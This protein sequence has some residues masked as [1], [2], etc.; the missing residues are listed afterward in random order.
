M[1]KKLRNRLLLT[2][3][4]ITAALIT[5]C[6]TVIFI[7]MEQNVSRNTSMALTGA[8]D[9]LTDMARSEKLNDTDAPPPA[10][11]STRSPHET[12]P[13]NDNDPD[14]GRPK[15]G[16]TQFS[17]ILMYT[18]DSYGNITDRSFGL[19]LTNE[20][21]LEQIK[22]LIPEI[23]SKDVESGNISVNGTNLEYKIRRYS[24][25]SALALG[26]FSAEHAILQ[27]LMIVLVLIE[28]FAL[29]LTL[30]IS[31]I[32][33]NRSIRPVEDSYNKQKQFVADASHELKT[34]LTTINTNIDV[35]LSHEDSLI[36]DEKKWLMYIRSENER[37][38]KLTNDLL[39]L[40]RLDH[41]ENTVYSDTSF[42]DAAE[43][44]ILAME[45]VAFERN[46]TVN[47]NIDDGVIVKA[48]PEQLR[49]LIMIL[50][51]NAIKYTPDGGMISVSLSRGRDAVL[52]I[53][54]SGAGIDKDDIKQIF[55]R[56]YRSDRSRARE[57]GGYG[58]GLAIA[59]AITEN[60][61]GV[62]SVSSKVNEYTEFYVSIP[63]E[64]HK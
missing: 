3:L 39:Y 37:M 4:L 10:Q 47:E 26:E 23:I 57:S 60:F 34:P 63:A 45:A 55:E 2:N 6:F 1:F 28:I 22:N 36:R 20:T 24:G 12:P 8:L 11:E 21:V 41:D 64:K 44:V 9:M 25:G 31:L 53:R 42:S 43:S 7:M 19:S 5:G 38:V 15:R 29:G 62:I 33:A 49:Q 58:L 61:G 32:I 59:K 27:R 18:V 30:F 52:K 54:N 14:P 46:I 35:L 17:S 50:M 56:F 13:P 48:S 51:D 16:N 40:A